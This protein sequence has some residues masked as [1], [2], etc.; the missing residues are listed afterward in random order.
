MRSRAVV[1][2]LIDLIEALHGRGVGLRIL[3]QGIDTTT[4][5]GRMFFRG[6]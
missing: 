3:D 6:H 1:R 4:R 2:N 5:A